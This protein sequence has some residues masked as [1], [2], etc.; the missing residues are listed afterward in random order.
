MRKTIAR[1]FN[2]LIKVSI[3]LVDASLQKRS[4]KGNFKNSNNYLF[5]PSCFST[6]GK[7]ERIFWPPEVNRLNLQS[8][9]KTFFNKLIL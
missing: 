4:S 2:F 5:T 6:N 9:N 3:P 8:V 7:T 1:F